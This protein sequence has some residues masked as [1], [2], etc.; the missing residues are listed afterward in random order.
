MNSYRLLDII[1]FTILAAFLVC[2]SSGGDHDH[3]YTTPLD[4]QT[5]RFLDGPVTGVEY[6]S[7]HWSHVTGFD[8]I[9]MTDIDGS[10]IFQPGEEVT[11]SIGGVKLGSTRPKRTVTPID[12]VPD[13]TNTNNTA[14]INMCRFLQS[15]DEDARPENGIVI[16][17]EVR[18]V[19][20]GFE[21]FDFNAPSLEE[22]P[23]V[24][25][26]FAELNVSEIFPENKYGVERSLVSAD[27]ALIHFEETLIR[28]EQ[29]EAAAENVAFSAGIR[30]PV[31][32]VI[33]FQGQSFPIIAWAS[34]GTEPYYFKWI[35]RNDEVLYQGSDPPTNVPDLAP[36]IYTLQLIASDSYGETVIDERLVTVRDVRDA[37]L[38]NYPQNNDICVTVAIQPR[39]MTISPGESITV[40]T[41]IAQGNPPFFYSWSYPSSVTY[42]STDNPPDA[43]FTFS[44]SGSY[45]VRITVQDTLGY[46]VFNDSLYVTVR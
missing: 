39:N 12:L 1:V 31:S 22:I 28:I 4:A 26:I 34:G 32:D 5:G 17:E 13:A 20:A 19:L 46:D 42:S 29:E 18:D 43:V 45:Q 15:L 21:S 2:C 27:D 16:S 41:N 9:L 44:T 7:D 33:L 30:K 10:F 36:G 3:P 37:S 25:D 35:L 6:S 40:T 23:E 14:V 8:G 11:F 38:N 24:Q